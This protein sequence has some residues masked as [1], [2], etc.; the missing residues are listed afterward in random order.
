M[1]PDDL[2]KRLKIHVET[3]LEYLGLDKD[4]DMSFR[5][6]HSDCDDRAF[7]R[8]RDFEKKWRRKQTAMFNG[9]EG[10]TPGVCRCGRRYRMRISVPLM[11]EA[12]LR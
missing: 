11:M 9:Y 8:F 12:R 5:T 4:G 2:K 3:Y 10:R 6:D 1:A 7:I